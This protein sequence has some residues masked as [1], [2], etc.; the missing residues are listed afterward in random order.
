[1]VET[2]SNVAVDQIFTIWKAFGVSELMPEVTNAPESGA[3]AISSTSPG[4]RL[5]NSNG[6]WIEYLPKCGLATY[7]T[8]HE[9]E[10]ILFP[11]QASDPVLPGLEMA[12][13]GA[14]AGIHQHKS[15]PAIEIVATDQQLAAVG[16]EGQ[17]C[18]R[19]SDVH[20]PLVLHIP[21]TGRKQEGRR[22]QNEK[23][24]KLPAAR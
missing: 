1:M 16:R 9:L 18:G 11:C 8:G 21:R 12:N 2:N 22:C 14:R 24:S 7:R 19:E 23:V 13:Y 3:K 10:S 17:A 20:V 6:I 15:H 5:P 4:M